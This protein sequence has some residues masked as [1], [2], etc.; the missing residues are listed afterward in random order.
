MQR[1]INNVANDYMFDV[2]NM[3]VSKVVGSDAKL[4]FG[5]VLYVKFHNFVNLA[6]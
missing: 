4:K 5:F 3:V 6:I 2:T 1:K